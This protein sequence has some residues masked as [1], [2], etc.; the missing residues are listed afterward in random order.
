M[1][2]NP[3]RSRRKSITDIAIVIGFAV[4]TAAVVVWALL[5]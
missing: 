2:F 1:G 4:V 5:G 3:F